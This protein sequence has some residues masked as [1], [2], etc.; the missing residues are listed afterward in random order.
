V[1]FVTI[2]AS[3]DRTARI[4]DAAT[5]KQIAVLS[6]HGKSVLSAAFSPDGTRIASDETA[7]MADLETFPA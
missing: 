7:R 1:T 4:W 2:T 5:A 3:R 6:G